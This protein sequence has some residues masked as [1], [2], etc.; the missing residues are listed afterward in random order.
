MFKGR[1][2]VSLRAG[3][4]VRISK[5]GTRAALIVCDEIKSR[6]GAWFSYTD[7]DVEF[8]E[9]FIAVK[10]SIR[11]GQIRVMCVSAQSNRVRIAIE[12]PRAWRILRESDDREEHV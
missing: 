3:E 1:L 11:V 5:P 9:S 7:G 2:V 10:A 8:P 4:R 6:S 12:A